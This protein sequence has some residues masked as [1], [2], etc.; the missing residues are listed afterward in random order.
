MAAVAASKLSAS[1]FRD[2]HHL[3]WA[4][5]HNSRQLFTLFE[6][7]LRDQYNAYDEEV[8]PRLDNIVT[9][10]PA[11]ALT[12]FVLS[13]TFVPSLCVAHWVQPTLAC[14]RAWHHVLKGRLF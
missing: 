5:R 10:R 12:C 4:L 2:D 13:A 1:E 9:V 6:Q 14:V 8:Q 3:V 11:V 7:T